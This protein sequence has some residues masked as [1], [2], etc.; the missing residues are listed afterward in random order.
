MG[1][2]NLPE[3]VTQYPAAKITVCVILHVLEYIMLRLLYY[4]IHIMSYNKLNTRTSV[5]V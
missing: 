4:S 5:M 3:V 2:N 1:V